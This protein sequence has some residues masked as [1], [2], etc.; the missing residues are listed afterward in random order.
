MSR[1]Q[2][3]VVTWL[4]LIAAILLSPL[5][6]ELVPVEDM[7]RTMPVIF[8]LI[9]VAAGLVAALRLTPATPRPFARGLIAGLAV[10]GVGFV[11]SLA[12]RRLVP[13]AGVGVLLWTLLYPLALSVAVPPVVLFVARV[14]E[15]R[16]A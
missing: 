12:V 15:E 6:A 9:I 8:G 10:Y 3:V 16:V 13:L 14:Q 11:V 7:L 2:I 4:A 5:I 1:L